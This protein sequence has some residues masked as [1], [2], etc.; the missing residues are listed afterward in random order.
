[1]AQNK[2]TKESNFQVF[3]PQIRQ[4]YPIIRAEI[5]QQE[6][7]FS[8]M[9]CISFWLRGRELIT[10][11][12]KDRFEINLDSDGFKCIKIRCDFL[13]RNVKASLS[14]KENENLRSGRIHENREEP[15]NFI[16]QFSE[17][18]L[19][20]RKKAIMG[21]HLPWNSFSNQDRNFEC[22]RTWDY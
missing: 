15:T 9:Y 16:E 21:F 14:Q 13:R 6:V 3:N 8:T 10:S 20:F 5:L 11:L 1:M 18:Y 22:V 7:W 19:R 12:K 2:A 4:N 17:M